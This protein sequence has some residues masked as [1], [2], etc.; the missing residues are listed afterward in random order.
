MS[1]AVTKTKNIGTAVALLVSTS[2]VPFQAACNSNHS[3][4]P[5]AKQVENQIC[6]EFVVASPSTGIYCF[7]IDVKLT[8]VSGL[9][10][11]YTLD[12]SEPNEHSFAYLKPVKIKQTT[13][14]RATSFKDGAPIKTSMYMYSIKK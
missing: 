10:I 9:E 13:I 4:E 11:K 1:R 7:P 2:L 3:K 5:L 6:S 12:G 14:L 8:S